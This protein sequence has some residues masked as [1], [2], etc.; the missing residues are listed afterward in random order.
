MADCSDDTAVPP[1]SN[2]A[3]RPRIPV[4]DLA[5]SENLL[6]HDDHRPDHVLSVMIRP[7]AGDYVGDG[8]NDVTIPIVP[9]LAVRSLGGVARNGRLG[10]A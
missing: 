9:Y 3:P 6:V 10:I 7:G 1:G 2:I 5:G 4:L 8:V